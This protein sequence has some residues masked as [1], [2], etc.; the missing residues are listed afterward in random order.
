[1]ATKDERKAFEEQLLAGSTPSTVE[2]SKR[3]LVD[4][5]HQSFGAD[6]LVKIKNFTSRT[7]GW[8]YSDHR[9]VE[10]GGT[11]ELSSRM[12]SPVGS[13]RESRR[14]VF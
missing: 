4:L 3:T 6:E 13:G 11:L 5:L 1:M 9:S 10:Q 2:G 12:N 7:T 14:L 8:V